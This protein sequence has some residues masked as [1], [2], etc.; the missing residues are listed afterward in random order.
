MNEFA[1]GTNIVDFA[2]VAAVHLF[3][4]LALGRWFRF[5]VLLPAFAVVLVES[6]AGDFRLGIAPWYLLL[7]AGIALVQLGYAAASRFSQRRPAE[8][9]SQ[10][11]QPSTSK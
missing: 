4:G 11:V 1:F 8:H 6:L 10:S 5:G 3:A 9:H 2:V 7:V